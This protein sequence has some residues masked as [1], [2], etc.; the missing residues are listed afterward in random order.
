[1]NDNTPAVSISNKPRSAPTSA[2][3]NVT[4]D[5]AS[6]SVAVKATTRVVP[7][8]TLTDPA[9]VTTGVLSFA[10]VTV[11]VISWVTNAPSESVAVTTTTYTLVPAPEPGVSQNRERF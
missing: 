6:A 7:S 11:T 5:P 2:T 4:V 8:A 10:S 3:V 1:M 9:D